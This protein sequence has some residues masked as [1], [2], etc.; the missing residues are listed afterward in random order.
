MCPE[1]PSTIYH[2]GRRYSIPVKSQQ[3]V[4]A[5]LRVLRVKLALELW[6]D[7]GK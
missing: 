5:S 4:K 6:V 1:I 7:S 3:E 2:K